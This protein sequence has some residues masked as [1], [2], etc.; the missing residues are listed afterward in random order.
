M[1]KPFQVWQDVYA[2]GGPEMSHPYDC[3]IY[4][5][6][7]EDLILID[8]GAGESF[9]R[10]VSNISSLGFNP[11]KLKAVVI[12]HAH[13]DHIGALHQLQQEFGVQVIAHDLEADAIESGK[14][15]GAEFYGVAYQPCLVNLRLKKTEEGL[16]FGQHELKAIHI[17]GHT[18]GSIA[19]YVDMGK[20]VLFGQDVHGPYFRQ[21]GADPRQAIASLQKLI[22]LRADILC[23]GH[24][25]IYQPTNEVEKY[26]L[27]YLHQLERLEIM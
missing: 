13:I 18:R 19:I 7:A 14:G 24:F 23:E 4:L 6:D 16:V 8:C 3:C 9:D 15:V 12:T 10:L 5:V 25:G 1:R 27:S 20:R 21:W 2:I 22:D 17:P 11:E 26:I